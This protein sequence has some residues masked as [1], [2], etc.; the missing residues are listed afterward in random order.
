MRKKTLL[1]FALSLV[2]FSCLKENLDP[3]NLD[4]VVILQVDY[5]TYQFEGGKEFSYFEQDTSTVNLPLTPLYNSP[6]VGDGRLSMLYAGDTI[7]DGTIM[8]NVDGGVK[9]YP[10]NIDHQIHYLRMETKISKPDDSRF[11]VAFYDL[12]TEPIK[13]DSIWHDISD[14][15]MVNRYLL[16]NTKAKIGLFLYRPKEGTPTN[17]GNWKWYV[18]L[19]N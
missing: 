10:E 11:Q 12:G 4:K 6:L 17:P 19:K 9:K 18:V 15:Q 1:L 5:K 2:L 8:W 13:Y 14:L 7:F 3:V 16:N